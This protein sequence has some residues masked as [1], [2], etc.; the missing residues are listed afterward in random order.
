MH[1]VA[2]AVRDLHLK[3]PALNA[4]DVIQPLRD[5]SRVGVGERHPCTPWAMQS[6]R[7]PLASR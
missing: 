7:S 4:E 6:R 1:D 5:C 2:C 3:L